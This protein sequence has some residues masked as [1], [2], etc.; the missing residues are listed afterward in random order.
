MQEI[1]GKEIGKSDTESSL[2]ELRTTSSIMYSKK[3]AI[4]VLKTSGLH[5]KLD[6]RKVCNVNKLEFKGIN[7]KAKFQCEIRRVIVARG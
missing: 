1:I 2:T 6:L 4:S 3:S 7:L 5:R